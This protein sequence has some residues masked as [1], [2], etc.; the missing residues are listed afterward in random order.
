MPSPHATSADPPGRTVAAV[1]RRLG[2]SPATLRTWHRR[3]GLGPAE[4]RS[5]RHRRYSEAD[6]DR[7]LVMRRLTYDGLTPADAARIARRTTGG[8]GDAF[9]PDEQRGRGGGGRAL[10][11]PKSTAATRG[12]S[13]AAMALDADQVVKL[14]QRSL[15]DQG[16][17]P[18]WHDMALPV[19]DAVGRYWADT[20][21][22]I[23]VEHLLTDCVAAAL[24]PLTVV[25]GRRSHRSVLLAGVEGD[26]HALPLYVLGAALAEHRI[27]SRILGP[28]VPHSALAAAVSR[29]GPHVVFVWAQMADYAD[30]SA[31]SL[32]PS[33]RPRT[34]VVVG[35]PG[36]RHHAHDLAVVVDDLEAAETEVVAAVG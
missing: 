3:Y 25:R 21:E 19:L 33:T 11:L 26:L 9:T 1:A 14:L 17:R 15:A 35:G 31:L 34:T 7:L 22:G 23:E 30:P 24:R 20:G 4:H 10:S 36:W 6:L 2:V 5:G 29:S 27:A 8:T 16:L 32:L 28:N 13:R 12:L 18:T